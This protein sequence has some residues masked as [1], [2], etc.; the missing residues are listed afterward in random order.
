MKLKGDPVLNAITL[1]VAGTA[2]TVTGIAVEGLAIPAKFGVALGVGLVAGGVLHLVL[3]ALRR[4]R[5][6]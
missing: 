2:G 1:I 5:S 3:R 4:A 6:G